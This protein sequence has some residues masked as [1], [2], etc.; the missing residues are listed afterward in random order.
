M[1][2][3]L[4]LVRDQYAADYDYPSKVEALKADIEAAAGDPA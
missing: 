2:P 1:N 4:Q 3:V